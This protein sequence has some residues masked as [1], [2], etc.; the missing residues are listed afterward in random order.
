MSLASKGA[1]VG[2][3]AV[4][5]VISAL[6]LPSDCRSVTF[7]SAIINLINVGG[8][9][10]FIPYL[11]GRSTAAFAASEFACFVLLG[12]RWSHPIH[13]GLVWLAIVAWQGILS[14]WLEPQP[15][16]LALGL[17]YALYAKFSTIGH[18]RVIV[19][20]FAGSIGR[21]CRIVCHNG[22]QI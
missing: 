12:L 1:I 21:Y 22:M 5:S 17:L 4:L 6:V 10:M 11:A 14:A 19:A 20:T 15:L 7:V 18:A 8:C 13:L 9:W 16:A 2:V 3:E